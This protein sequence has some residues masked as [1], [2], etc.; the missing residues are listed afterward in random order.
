ML[1][2]LAT[3]CA[4]ESPESMPAPAVC[5]PPVEP[6]ADVAAELDRVCPIDDATGISPCPA[7]D[8]FMG[9]TQVLADQLKECRR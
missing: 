7:I 3:G 1:A 6:G 9:A 4:G 5:P 2:A 8:R